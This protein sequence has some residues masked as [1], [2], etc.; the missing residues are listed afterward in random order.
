MKWIYSCP[1]EVLDLPD[2]VLQIVCLSIAIPTS[3]A[4]D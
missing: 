2:F 1:A 4:G 3:K